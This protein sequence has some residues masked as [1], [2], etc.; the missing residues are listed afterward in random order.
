MG[1]DIHSMFQKRTENGWQ[2]I[3]SGYA[4]DR[5]YQLFAV[6]A[7][8]RNGHGF[9]GV[10]TGEPVQPISEPRGLPEDFEMIKNDHPVSSTD[11]LPRWDD[12]WAEDGEAPHQWMGE[13]SYSWLTGKEMLDWYAGA[14]EVVRTGIVDR[15]VYE[16]W[17]GVGPPPSW[18]GGITGRNIRITDET[19]KNMIPDW[20]HIRCYWKENLREKLKYF[21]DE[22][23]R[24]QEEHGEIR[25]VFG[26][27]S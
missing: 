24:L 5:D 27:D 22:V 8:V 21:F 1:T 12:S 3:K 6:L 25:F 9:A 23:G 7:G 15:P 4:E 10:V 16:A 20:T 11:L 26:F 17:D 13:H 2:D 19:G 14:S 18:C